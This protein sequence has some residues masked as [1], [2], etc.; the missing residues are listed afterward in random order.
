VRSPARRPKAASSTSPVAASDGVNDAT[1]TFAW[2]ITGTSP[3][4]VSITTQPTAQVSGS[5]VTFTAAATNAVNVKYKWSFGDGT[6]ETAY[7]TSASTTHT[8]TTA[9]RFFVT[10]TATDDR[11]IETRQTVLQTIYLPATANKP[12]SSANMVLQTPATGNPR[13]WVV[14]QD[15]DTVSV[16]DAVTYAKLA[17]VA[18]GAAPRTAAVASNGMVWVTN[19]QG[20]SITVINASTFAVSRTISLARGSEPYGI[21]MAPSGAFALI[22]LEG[23]GQ[24]VKYSTSTYAQSGTAL[25]VG[26]HSRHVSINSASTTAYVSQF[27]TPPLPGEGTA[28]VTTTGVGGQ[29]AVV[30]ATAMTLT[31]TVILAHSDKVDAENSGQRRAQLP[32]AGRDFAGRHAG[33]GAVQAGQ[34]QARHAAQRLPLNFQNTVRAI[35][36]RINCRPTSRRWPRASTTTTPAWRALR[37]TTRTATTCSWRSRPAGRSRWS[38][39]WAATSCSLRHRHRAAGGSWSRPT[40]TRCSVNNFMD[41]TVNVMDVSGVM[42]TG[43]I[44]APL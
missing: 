16:F 5:A 27:I 26:V 36:S 10:V 9:G 21:A 34:H 37:L 23:T 42:K 38:T 19:K 8:F 14:N 43:A 18:T 7:S 40:A 24:V 3:L 39:H 13:L 28:S 15:N 33:L 35:S 44:L 30:N 22:V 11:G 31:S 2:N 1:T 25:A 6:A 4:A 20:S 17:E 29:V 32:R 41:R 12:T